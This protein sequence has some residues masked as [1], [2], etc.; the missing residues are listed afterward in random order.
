MGQSQ[1]DYQSYLLRL[2]RS[3]KEE[4]WRAMLEAVDNNERHSFANL[5]DL[6]AFL[7]SK[8]GLALEQHIDAEK[9]AANRQQDP[10]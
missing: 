1:T 10:A 6:V 3:G 9:Q 2:W 7:R 4:P 8:T 5:E